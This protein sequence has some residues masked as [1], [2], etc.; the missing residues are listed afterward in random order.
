[1]PWFGLSS[2]WNDAISERWWRIL[3]PTCGRS[4]RSV[5]ESDAGVGVV[6]ATKHR[7]GYDLAG[8]HL[9]VAVMEVVRYAL[10]DALMWPRAVVVV[11]VFLDNVLQLL[12]MEDERVVEALSLEASDGAFADGIGLWSSIGRLQLLDG[13]ALDD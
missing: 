11:G 1:M 10:L 9:W 3:L 7:S 6:Q 5:G 13:G 8:L 2:N 4:D 12:A